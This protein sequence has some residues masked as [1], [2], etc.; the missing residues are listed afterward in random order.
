MKR[1]LI[2]IFIVIILTVGV[3][4]A[5]QVVRIAPLTYSAKSSTT[6]VTTSATALPATALAGREAIAI[7]N[8]TAATVTVYIGGSDV[9]TSNG[10]PLTSSAPAI[11]VDVDDSVV[12]YGICASSADVRTLEV[13]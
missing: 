1:F 6:T 2:Y 9:T 8:T 11:T 10:F 3:V 12:I 13:K 5:S 7:Y 4:Y